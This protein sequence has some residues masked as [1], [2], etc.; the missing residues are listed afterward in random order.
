M[1]DMKQNGHNTNCLSLLRGK[2]DGAFAENMNTF[3]S[4]F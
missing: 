3:Y 1:T 4:R 2:D